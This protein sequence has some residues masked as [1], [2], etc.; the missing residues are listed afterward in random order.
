VEVVEHQAQRA[1]SCQRADE[2]VEP[3]EGLTLH[4]VARQVVHSLLLL[5]LEHQ[6][7]Q[8]GEK[9]IGLR[10]VIAEHAGELRP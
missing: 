5:R 2:L 4:G 6:A 9:G 8:R 10:R 7:E 3:V 1:L